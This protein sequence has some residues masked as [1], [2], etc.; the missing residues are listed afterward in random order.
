M[1]IRR[2]NKKREVLDSFWALH[3]NDLKLHGA[4]IK[5]RTIFGYTSSKNVRSPRQ[6][7]G[8]YK[9]KLIFEN[10]PLDLPQAKTQK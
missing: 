8:G 6:F 4:K 9:V 2:P 1:R 5:G 7:S 3:R 10:N